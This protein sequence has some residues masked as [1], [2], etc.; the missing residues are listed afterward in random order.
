MKYFTDTDV[1]KPVDHTAISMSFMS[2][3]GREHERIYFYLFGQLPDRYTF[4]T[5]YKKF[6]P[7]LLNSK[8]FDILLFRKEWDI[9]NSYKNKNIKMSETYIINGFILIT[10]VEKNE[11]SIYFHANT[12]EKEV[13]VANLLKLAKKCKVVVKDKL[14]GA[15]DALSIL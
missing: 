13:V 12:A 6:N 11:V 1:Y 2:S 10:L 5:N 15:D 9:D 4:P 14:K 8:E 3:I 7:R